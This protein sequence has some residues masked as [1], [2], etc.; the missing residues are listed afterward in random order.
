MNP[1]ASQPHPEEL[2][3]PFKDALHEF[4][5]RIASGQPLTEEELERKHELEVLDTEAAVAGLKLELAD[6]RQRQAVGEDI[7]P[8]YVQEL[9]EELEANQAHL[10]DLT[11]EDII[12]ADPRIKALEPV[13]YEIIN[14]KHALEEYRK[15]EPT[16]QRI[17]EIARLEAIVRELEAEARRISQQEDTSQ[18]G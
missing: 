12:P 11:G 9:R 17:A 7:D 4:E 14:R 6:V 5:E 13:Y 10:R 16:P 8:D 1:E 3:M 18:S 2:P 15:L